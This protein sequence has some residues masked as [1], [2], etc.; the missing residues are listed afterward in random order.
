MT[1]C[2]YQR[3]SALSPDLVMHSSTLFLTEQPK[4]SK[5]TS[6]VSAVGDSHHRRW[7]KLGGVSPTR[8]WLYTSKDTATVLSCMMACQTSSNQPSSRTATASLFHQRQGQFVLLA[9]SAVNRN[10]YLADGQ[11]FC[12]WTLSGLCLCLLMDFLFVFAF[13]NSFS[14]LSSFP[15]DHVGV[16][17]R[18]ADSSTI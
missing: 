15:F 12:V 3:T 14:E 2:T 4:V 13:S 1:S 10:L 18:T 5:L 9:L 11:V 8:V 17:A 6:M 7:L 16:V